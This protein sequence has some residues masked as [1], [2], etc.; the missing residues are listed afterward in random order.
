[1]SSLIER[2]GR[3]VPAGQVLF[4]EGDSGK[5]MFVIQSGKVRLMR[6]IRGQDKLLAELGAG[7]GEGAEGIWQEVQAR[8]SA[9]PVAQ[10]YRS[11]IAEFAMEPPPPEWDGVYE[12]KTK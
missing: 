6:T 3:T 10:Y 9:D 1:M 7:E 11:R 8:Y 4:R 2:F 5:E 12:F